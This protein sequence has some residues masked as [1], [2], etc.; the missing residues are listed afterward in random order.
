MLDNAK[1]IVID[2]ASKFGD[3]CWMRDEIA[4][5]PPAQVREFAKHMKSEAAKEGSIPTLTIRESN[6]PK[7]ANEMFVIGKRSSQ[8]DKTD[9]IMDTRIFD[10]TFNLRTGKMDS[11][12][13]RSIKGYSNTD[14]KFKDYKNEK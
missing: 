6:D 4:S 9:K 2:Q 11:A 3:G 8:G 7:K 12:S 13:C 10:A 5:M 14:W 1:L